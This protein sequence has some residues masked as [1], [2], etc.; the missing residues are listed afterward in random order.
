[1]LGGYD[2]PEIT[3]HT[4]PQARRRHAEHQEIG[5]LYSWTRRCMNS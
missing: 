5:F 3:L 2:H 4:P 1:M